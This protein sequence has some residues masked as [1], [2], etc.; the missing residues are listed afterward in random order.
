MRRDSIRAEKQCAELQADCTQVGVWPMHPSVFR[1]GPGSREHKAQYPVAWGQQLYF[2]GRRHLFFP[3]SSAFGTMHIHLFKQFWFWMSVWDPLP[4]S[5]RPCRLSLSSWRQNSSPPHLWD[6]EG[7]G[8][9]SWPSGSYPQPFLRH[10]F[11]IILN[12]PQGLSACLC[13]A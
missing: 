9:V 11:R 3:V 8:P 1:Q 2:Q 13:P 10:G 7:G 12:P 6:H 5:K 4:T